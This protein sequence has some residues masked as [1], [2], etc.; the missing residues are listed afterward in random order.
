MTSEKYSAVLKLKAKTLQQILGRPTR[1]HVNK[2]CGAIAAGYA[3]A[4]TSHNSFPLYPK[5]GLSAAF[6]KK[7][8]YI[9][10]HNTLANS[11]ATTTNLATTWS[12][13]HPSRT[14]TYDNTILVVHPD[15]SRSKKEAQQA[16]LITQYEIFEGY[17]EAFK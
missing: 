13:T 17:K 4:K 6:L 10:L 1:E 7:N 12:F 15:I 3:E 16:E 8:K 11:L 2:M 5:I 14:D 9:A